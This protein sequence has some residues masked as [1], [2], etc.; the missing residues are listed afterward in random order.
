MHRMMVEACEKWASSCKKRTSACGAIPQEHP[1]GSVTALSCHG[2]HD[3][4]GDIVLQGEVGPDQ[5]RIWEASKKL[6]AMNTFLTTRALRVSRLR[7][8]DYRD[9]GSVR[10]ASPNLERDRRGQ[11]TAAVWRSGLGAPQWAKS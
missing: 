7:T 2:Q 8:N 6:W 10:M 1:R 4:L 3:L 11:L 5:V 9:Q